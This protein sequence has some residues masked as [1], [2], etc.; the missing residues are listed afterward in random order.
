V[1]ADDQKT[2]N[3]PKATSPAN[4]KENEDEVKGGDSKKDG[5]KKSGGDKDA[6][7]TIA[8]GKHAKG[9]V[10]NGTS[11][12]EIKT[13]L[14]DDTAKTD[15]TTGTPKHAASAGASASS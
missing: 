1:A 10:K 7:G 9:T 14:G 13:K 3:D 6:G 4:R 12:D 15:T 8:A 5:D 11:V 2:T